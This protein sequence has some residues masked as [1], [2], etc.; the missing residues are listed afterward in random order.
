MGRRV[1]GRRRNSKGVSDLLGIRRAK[2]I[3][4]EEQLIFQD[5]TADTAAE[6]VIGQMPER[7]AKV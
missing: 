1:K 4:K 5:R 3:A 6:V 2:V 7:W